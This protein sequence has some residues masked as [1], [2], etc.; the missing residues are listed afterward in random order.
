MRQSRFTSELNCFNRTIKVHWLI[1]LMF[2]G[3]ISIGIRLG[4]WQLERAHEKELLI[5]KHQTAQQ[6]TRPL[7]LTSKLPMEKVIDYHPV[8]VSGKYVNNHVVF[9]ANETAKG[10]DGYHIYI[11][12]E[13]RDRA[14][15]WLNL[16]W[17]KANPDRRNLPKIKPLPHDIELLGSIYFSK[18]QPILFEGALQQLNENQWLLQ[19][20]DHELLASTL[21]HRK[22]DVLPYIIRVSPQAE[23]GYL[24][25]WQIIA[26]PPEKHIAYAVQWFGLALTL[27]VLG[28]ILMIKKR[29]TN[30]GL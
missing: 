23:I 26:M 9:M 5:L 14:I 10:Q 29:A 24:R 28:F 12:I 30:D 7:L 6:A 21:G 19:G 22:S 17:I 8:K 20:R 4:V 15:V 25:E 18:G 11:P 13:L 3:L 16:G 2:I 1:A 27:L